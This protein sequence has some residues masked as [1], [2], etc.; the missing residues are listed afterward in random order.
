ML[1]TG[2][3]GTDRTAP[4]KQARACQVVPR[5]RVSSGPSVA[6]QASQPARVIQ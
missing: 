2:R 3:A 6:M 1:T 5:S 4:S